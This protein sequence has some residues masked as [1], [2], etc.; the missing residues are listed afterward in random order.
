VRFIICFVPFS[1]R[2]GGA[3]R[4]SAPSGCLSP[5]YLTA[6]GAGITA[7]ADVTNTG[8]RS[9]DEVVQLYIHDPVAS[10]SQP[11]R[12]LRDFERVTLDPGQTKTVQFTLDSSDV[13][14]YDNS[15]RFVVEPGKIDVYVGN[16]SSAELNSSFTVVR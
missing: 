5:C 4:C 2:E 12:R 15:G 6:L 9:G 7:A 14:F 10:I 1:V 13:G 3:S 11:V 16:S 8:S